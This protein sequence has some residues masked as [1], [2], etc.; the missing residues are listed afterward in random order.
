MSPAP[1]KVKLG[2]IQTHASADP[3]DNLARQLA[4]VEKAADQGAQIVCTQELFRSEYFC[5]EEN[6]KYFELAE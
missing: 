1:T 5:Q 2:L 6:H 4:L 3:A